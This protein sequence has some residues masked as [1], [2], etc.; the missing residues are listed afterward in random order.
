MPQPVDHMN[1]IV[2]QM[3]SV[4][5]QQHDSKYRPLKTEFAQAWKYLNIQD[6]HEKSLKIEFALKV[7]EKHSKALKR[8]WILPFARGFNTDFEGL[9]Q[10]KIVMPLFGAAYAAPN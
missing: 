5:S 3:N 2:D 7:L 10:Y 9:N 4:F 1:S 8:P 6:C